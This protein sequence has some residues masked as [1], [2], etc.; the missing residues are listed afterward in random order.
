MA[1]RSALPYSQEMGDLMNRTFC[2]SDKYSE[3]QGRADRV[4]A[5]LP[6]LEFERAF[7]RAMRVKDIP[8]F[9][10]SLCRNGDDQTRL[11]IK[12]VSKA[13]A[14]QSPHNYGAAVDLIH[15]TKG[16]QLTRKQW[17]IV[18]H[19]GKQVAA[20]IRVTYT[21]PDGSIRTKPLLLTWGGD[22]EFYDPAHW[23]MTDWREI[24]DQYR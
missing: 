1:G 24:R 5:Q 10:H 19:I 11:Y 20:R 17:D 9:A 14:G 22:W 8:M 13:R 6:I 21:A 16:W 4:G 18:G 12:G 23:E 3:Q 2:Q 7:V 15:G